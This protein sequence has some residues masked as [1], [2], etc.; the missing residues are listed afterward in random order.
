MIKG[1]SDACLQL[2]AMNRTSYRL[3]LLDMHSDAW[4]GTRH[5]CDDGF[6]TCQCGGLRLFKRRDHQNLSRIN[7]IRILEHRFVCLEDNRVFI[8]IT[9]NLFGNF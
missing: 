8:C 2:A 5:Y 4:S 9:I 1:N 7:Q 6:Q 3:C